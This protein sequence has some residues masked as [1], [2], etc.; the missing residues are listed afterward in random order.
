MVNNH[1]FLIT[2]GKYFTIEELTKSKTATN[3]KIDNTPSDE[4]VDNLNKLI[5]LLDA[6]RELYEKPIYVNSGYRC[7]ELNKLVG[8]VNTSYHLKGLAV[9]ITVGNSK[10]NKE[11]FNLIK[12]NFEFDKLINEYNYSWIHLQISNEK[13]RKIILNI[14]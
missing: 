6:I 8:G 5:T 13:N 4:I 7:K 3:L 2:M 11:L 10:S 1:P 9:D 14:C 12:D